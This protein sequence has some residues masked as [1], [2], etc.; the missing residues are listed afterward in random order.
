MAAAARTARGQN[1]RHHDDRAHHPGKLT[2]T[3][4]DL[5][6]FVINAKYTLGRNT[7]NTFQQA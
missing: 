5:K 2:L 6:G 4:L 7:G 3:R 1:S